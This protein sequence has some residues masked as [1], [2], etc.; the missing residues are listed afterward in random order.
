MNIRKVAFAVLAVALLL[1][2]CGGRK[3]AD[4]IRVG[5]F[6]AL[7]GDQAVWGQNELNTVKMLFEEYN[8]KGG[9]EVGGRK[10]KLE[11]IGYDNRG[12]PQ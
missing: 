6:G 3:D 8:A 1:A 5:W 10:Y 4:T 2:G 7:T 9:I 12:D 11:V